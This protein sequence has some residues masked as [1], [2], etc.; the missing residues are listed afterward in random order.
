MPN[1]LQ[2][3]ADAFKCVITVR[4]RIENRLDAKLK[5]SKQVKATNNV[6][7]VDRRNEPHMR[8]RK[9]NELK[10]IPMITIN[11]VNMAKCVD[12]K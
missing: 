8:T 6:N 10:I 1:I 2:N 12:D 5:R 9:T 4:N 11:D 3:I 7:D